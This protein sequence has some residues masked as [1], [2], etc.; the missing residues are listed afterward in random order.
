MP[1][2]N[3]LQLFMMRCRTRGPGLGTRVEMNMGISVVKPA[4]FLSGPQWSV[5]LFF[6][7]YTCVC[8]TAAALFSSLFS[9]LDDVICG[10]ETVSVC[11]L[12]NTNL[13]YFK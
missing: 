8:S 2:D 5:E 4:G 3:Y 7:C 1:E 10:A 13:F 6:A 9:L 11:A 12:F